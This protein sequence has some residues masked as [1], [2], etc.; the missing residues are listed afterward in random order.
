MRDRVL[1]SNGVLYVCQ[2]DI[3]NGK[4]NAATLVPGVLPV[5][6]WPPPGSQALPEGARYFKDENPTTLP[7]SNNA[8]RE[9]RSTCSD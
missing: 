5:R 3:D 4:I 7:A 8:L 6:G 1:A 9:L 2:R